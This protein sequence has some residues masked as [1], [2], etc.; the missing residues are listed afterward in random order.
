M[1]PR[2]TSYVVVL[3]PSKGDSKTQC[4]KFEQQAAISPKRYEIG[5]QLLLITNRKSIRAFDWHRPRW[6]WITL[7]DVIALIMRFFT[8]SDRFSGGLYHSGWRF[9]A[10]TITHPAA[11]SLCDS[12]ASCST[13]GKLVCDFLLGSNIDLAHIVSRTVSKLLLIIG[14]RYNHVA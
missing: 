6:P 7:N 2:W 4:P 11:R 8:E 14:T 9:L 1:S 3:K 13:N 12:W 10:K 5:C